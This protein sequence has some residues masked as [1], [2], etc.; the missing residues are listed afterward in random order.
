MKK[1]TKIDDL[2][3]VIESKGADYYLLSTSDEFLN[4]YVPE[5]NMRLVAY[6]ILWI[7]WDGVDI[8]KQKFFFTDGRYTL[9]AQKELEN[10]FEILDLN[11]TSISNF[12]KKKLKKK[13]SY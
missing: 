7:E 4:E 6:K 2:V 11:K 5:Y 9:Q 8:K 3:T 10:K 1:E 13:N 12:I